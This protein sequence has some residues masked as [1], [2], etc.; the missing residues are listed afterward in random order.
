MG[1]STGL[2]EHGA[3]EEFPA[4]AKNFIPDIQPIAITLFI[5]MQYI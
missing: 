3:E 2:F 1:S 4:P 5:Y